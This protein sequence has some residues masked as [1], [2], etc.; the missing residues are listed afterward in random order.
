MTHNSKQMRIHAHILAPFDQFE[1]RSLRKIIDVT[2]ESW[3]DTKRLHDPEE[4]GERLNNDNT[5]IL[6]VEADFIFKELFETAP[7]LKFVG[8]CRTS[9]NHVDLEEATQK[10]ILIVNTPA[11]NAQA[12]AEHALGLILSLARQIPK[13]HNYVTNKHWVN[14]IEPY[15]AMRGIE[16]SGKTIGIIG[17]GNAGKKLAKISHAL[18]M[19][20]LSYDPYIKRTSN[21]VTSTDLNNLLTKS[22]FVSI[23]APLTP[24]TENMIDED[25]IRIMKSTAYLINLS[26]SAIISEAA[27]H[28]ALLNGIIAGAALD[29]FTT[30]PISPNSPLL[31]LENV[32]LTPHIG[33]ATKE[34][35]QRHSKMMS[36]DIQC[37]LK[38]ERPKNLVNPNVWKSIV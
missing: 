8:V 30:H 35:I 18:N 4:L 14:P 5:S 3:L 31:S 38:G 24:E 13:A 33:G 22:D 6:V 19:K 34:T 7:N 28:E 20:I 2:Y 11:R 1:L 17:L 12:V 21:Y 25:Q 37:Y 15:I 27:L 26:N 23:H 9:I 32:V 16:L 36:D 29:I 10:G